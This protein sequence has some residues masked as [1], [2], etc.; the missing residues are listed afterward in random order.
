MFDPAAGSIKI[1]AEP[2]L[3]ATKLVELRALI[4][5]LVPCRSVQEAEGIGHEKAIS[6]AIGS[7][8][9]SPAVDLS[10]PGAGKP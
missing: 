7:V 3:S 6:H 2:R 10:E 1:V 4:A 8:R 9:H 5:S